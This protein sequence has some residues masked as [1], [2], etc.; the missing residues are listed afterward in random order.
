V[1]KQMGELRFVWTP[2]HQRVT[3]WK[4]IH[5]QW[6]SECVAKPFP[7]MDRTH[8]LQHIKW[9]SSVASPETGRLSRS[10]PFMASLSLAL[11]GGVQGA[12]G[13]PTNHELSNQNFVD[14]QQLFMYYD[15]TQQWCLPICANLW[16]PSTAA[17]LLLKPEVQAWNFMF[18]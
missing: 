7:T 5:H 10:F 13:A 1:A 9:E 16:I 15:L 11:V 12:R 18:P 3:G 4:Q 6:V 14:R 2:H 17:N 8:H